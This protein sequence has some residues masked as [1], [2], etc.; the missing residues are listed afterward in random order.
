MACL[1]RAASGGAAQI[2]QGIKAL[3]LY[4][5]EKPFSQRVEALRRRELAYVRC[6]ALLDAG[7]AVIF[8]GARPCSA[9]APQ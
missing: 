2:V 9:L 7:N 4:A 6:S 1:R 8:W 3:K 5:W